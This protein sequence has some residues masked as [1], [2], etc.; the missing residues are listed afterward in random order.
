MIDK[1][2]IPEVARRLGYKPKQGFIIYR[3]RVRRGG[4]KRPVHKDVTFGKPVN[5]G[6]NQLKCYFEI[7]LVDPSHKAIRRDAHI[8]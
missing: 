3:I 6:V 2:T 1:K 4:R 8:N 5:E 7:I